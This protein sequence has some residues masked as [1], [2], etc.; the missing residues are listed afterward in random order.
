MKTYGEVDVQIYIFLT[1]IL[2]LAEW[3][4]LRPCRSTPGTHWIAGWTPQQVWKIWSS[5]DSW[6]YRD[7][8]SNSYS[9]VVQSIAS[10]FTDNATTTK[11]SRF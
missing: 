11:E 4:A 1:L 9:S 8:N 5:E 6:P 10:R 2:V 7:S 3:Q